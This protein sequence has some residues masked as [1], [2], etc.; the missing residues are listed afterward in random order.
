MDGLETCWLGSHCWCS[1][2]CI[3]R[4][5]CHVIALSLMGN[6]FYFIVV[7]KKITTKQKNTEKNDSE[8]NPPLSYDCPTQMLLL[9]KQT[10]KNQKIHRFPLLPR[11]GSTTTLVIHLLV[12]PLFSILNVTSP[13]PQPYI[14]YLHL[15]T[16]HNIHSNHFSNPYKYSYQEQLHLFISPFNSAV[17]KP[18]RLTSL[19]F[20][21][22]RHSI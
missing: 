8:I 12:I 4:Q 3:S 13:L 11:P 21:T 22:L 7:Y 19:V 2:F 10:K 5:A 20:H 9:G 17:T 6:Y 1:W 18:P 14:P 15:Y 16:I